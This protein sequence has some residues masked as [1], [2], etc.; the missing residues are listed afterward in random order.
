MAIIPY[1]SELNVSNQI[2]DETLRFIELMIGLLSRNGYVEN[3][4]RLEY[5]DI[6]IVT[7][8]AL[9]STEEE[10]GHVRGV[11]RFA[12]EFYIYY[13]PISAIGFVSGGRDYLIPASAEGVELINHL[14]LWD[15][16]DAKDS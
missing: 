13:S 5:K 6:F 15:N 10:L 11:V 4:V 2:S 8:N 1:H 12:K 16:I 3:P 9:A 7:T 14:I